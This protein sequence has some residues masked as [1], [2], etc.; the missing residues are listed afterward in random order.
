VKFV[1]VQ[2]SLY[3][4]YFLQIFPN[5]PL[6]TLFSDYLFFPYGEIPRFTPIQTK[7]EVKS[8]FH[9]NLC[10]C[11]I[12]FTHVPLLSNDDHESK[13]FEDIILHNLGENCDRRIRVRANWFS[14]VLPIIGFP[15]QHYTASHHRITRLEAF[16]YS[17]FNTLD[18]RDAECLGSLL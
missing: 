13:D 6:R 11:C 5:L 12:C 2:F 10:E 16:N 15:P 7:Q 1:T 8:K 18:K 17:E 3:S 9:F 4:F 14:K